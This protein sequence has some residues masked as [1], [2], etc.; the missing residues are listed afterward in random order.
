VNFIARPLGI[1]ENDVNCVA[2]VIALAYTGEA[3]RVD[4]LLN[5]KEIR[6]GDPPHC[7]PI[8]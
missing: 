7:P 8:Y 6:S 1:L 4:T 3:R 2:E 5:E